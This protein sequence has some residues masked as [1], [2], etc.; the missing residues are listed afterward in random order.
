MTPRPPAAKPKAKATARESFVVPPG[1]VAA[2]LR[3]GI[4]GGSFNPP[5]EGH[6]YASELAMKQLGLDYVWWLVSPQNP[7][8]PTEGMVGLTKRLAAARTLAR[9]PR[10]VVSDIEMA[11]KTRFTADT[12]A[13]LKRRFPQVTFVWLMGSDNLV[14]I[15]RW[16]RW[17]NIFRALPVAVVAREGSILRARAGAAAQ[18]FAAFY[19]TPDRRFAMLAPPA[20]T[21]LDG[22]RNPLS[23]TALRKRRR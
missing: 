17:R 8:K 7:L 14:Q 23:S 19:R 16:K 11:L 15:P 22:R 21:W 13:E 9:H 12:V 4:L 5:H 2:G 1:P 18:I 6:V 20:W 10:I 3:I